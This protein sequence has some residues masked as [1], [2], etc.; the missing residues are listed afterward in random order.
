MHHIMQKLWR[1]TYLKKH[2]FVENKPVE[3]RWQR[4]FD[5]CGDSGSGSKELQ[6][7]CTQACRAQTHQSIFTCPRSEPYLLTLLCMLRQYRLW[8]QPVLCSCTAA[9][10]Q[11]PVFPAF[12]HWRLRVKWDTNWCQYMCVISWATEL[13]WVCLL[14][15]CSK[16]WA[17]RCSRNS[18]MSTHFW[19]TKRVTVQA[20]ENI[21][22]CRCLVNLSLPSSCGYR[23]ASHLCLCSQLY[24]RTCWCQRRI[25]QELAFT[26]IHVSSPLRRPSLDVAFLTDPAFYCTAM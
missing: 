22:R 18:A 11:N 9:S 15:S 21:W 12:M 2:I 5:E 1:Q 17:A 26:I 6:F 8:P 13:L 10:G 3:L 4:M 14:K 16:R 7:S 23:G 19:Q 20:S 25:I 24:V